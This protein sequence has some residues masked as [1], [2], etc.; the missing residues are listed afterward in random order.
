MKLKILLI[1]IRVFFEAIRISSRH[2]R[3][4]TIFLALW[5]QVFTRPIKSRRS[6]WSY[7]LLQVIDDLLDG[8]RQSK[9][10]PLQFV[11]DLKNQINFKNYSNDFWGN[12]VEETMNLFESDPD[13]WDAR[14]EFLNIIDNMML[15]HHRMLDRKAWDENQLIQHHR[16][17]F[18]PS[19]NLLL[20]SLDSKSRVNQMIEL[21]DVMGWCSMIRDLDDDLSRGLNNLPAHLRTE[22]DTQNWLRQQALA[23]RQNVKIAE[24]KLKELDP[25][26]KRLGQL[27]LKSAKKYLDQELS[28]E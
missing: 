12:L 27:F 26:A 21:V 9:V 4:F 18:I 6:R 3:Y 14:Y 8:H 28:H 24:E 13:T 5:S 10:P 22:Q 7:V 15:D 16:E 17:T 19:L 1:E 20:M 23:A 25:Q 11:K 2:L